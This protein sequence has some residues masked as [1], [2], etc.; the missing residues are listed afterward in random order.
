VREG[1]KKGRREGGSEGGRAMTKRASRPRSLS[2]CRHLSM[3]SD[4]RRDEGREGEVKKNEG[5]RE[6]GREGVPRELLWG[7]I[8]EFEAASGLEGGRE[9]GREGGHVPRELLWGDIQELEATLR[10]EVVEL[11]HDASAFR[12][13]VLREG[14][15]EGGWMGG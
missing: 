9:E 10:L 12:F 15:R 13:V 14:G 6:G 8:L 5:R 3:E 7:D 11:I 4:L 2:R 1:E